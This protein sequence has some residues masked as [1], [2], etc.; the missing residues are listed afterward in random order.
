MIRGSFPANKEIGERREAEET[1]R[2]TNF[3]EFE[4]PS[5]GY[6]AQY[7]NADHK[8]VGKDGVHVSG[9]NIWLHPQAGI[10]TG[11]MCNSSAGEDKAESGLRF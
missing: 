9:N 5:T 8:H 10:M 1:Q 11:S 6:T 2:H 4:A 3:V 7:G